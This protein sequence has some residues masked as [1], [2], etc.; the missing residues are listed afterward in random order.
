MANRVEWYSPTISGAYSNVAISI[1]WYTYGTSCGGL[2]AELD[3]YYQ[4]DGGGWVH[5]ANPSSAGAT[6]GTATA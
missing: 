3:I 6:S 4:L 1:D 5:M 2:E